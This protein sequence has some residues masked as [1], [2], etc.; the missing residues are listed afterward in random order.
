MQMIA[1]RAAG[2]SPGAPCG[3]VIHSAGVAGRCTR[4]YE[5]QAW[6]N[7]F[8]RVAGVDEVGRGALFGP[9][10]AAAVI[11]NPARRIPGLD[12]S[13][14]LTAAK[15]RLLA[16]RI[17]D[18]ALSWAVG[19]IV[20]ERIDAWN[21]YQASRQ[22]MEQALAQLD[23]GPDYVLSDAL[24]LALPVPC[25]SLVHGDARSVSIAA[26]SILAKVHRDLLLEALDREFPGYGLA[27]HKGYATREHLERLRE[28][29][30]TPL[31]RRSF[32]PVRECLA[33]LHAAE[34]NPLPF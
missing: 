28:H 17:R 13:K 30:P 27:R 4:R 24:P 11:L 25:R 31:H 12:D 2:V 21:I 1:L 7:G 26:A 9:V 6:Q 20:P 14:K 18:R 10:V 33:I 22:A 3:A 23:P 5:R 15:R 19:E 34:Q 32:A 29:G 8:R 16:E